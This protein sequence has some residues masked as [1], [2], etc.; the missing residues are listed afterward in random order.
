MSRQFF[1]GPALV[2]LWDTTST[3]VLRGSFPF[4]EAGNQPDPRIHGVPVN[5]C[6][7]VVDTSGK[8]TEYVLG[9]RVQGQISFLVLPDRWVHGGHNSL[10]PMEVT[11]EEIGRILAAKAAGWHI[12]VIAHRE[13][14][15]SGTTIDS[16][17]DV[18]VSQCFVEHQGVAQY[19]R[20]GILAF[21]SVAV[22]KTAED[23]AK[24]V[25]PL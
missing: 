3:P 9:V 8:Q 16:K 14:L 24:Y 11:E 15:G 13:M 7:D 21:S 5:Q 22:Y 23:I 20:D 10:S 12:Q 2:L 19:P 1:T 17:F 6:A 25:T 18:L 4:S